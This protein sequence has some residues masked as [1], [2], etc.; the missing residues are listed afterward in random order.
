MHE[1]PCADDSAYKAAAKRHRCL[2]PA[3]CFLEWQRTEGRRSSHAPQREI[4]FVVIILFLADSFWFS[5]VQ[6]G[7]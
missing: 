3:S 5:P 1:K 6:S 7:E 2:I 4:F